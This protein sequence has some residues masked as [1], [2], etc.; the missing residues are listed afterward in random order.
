VEGKVKAGKNQV[1]YTLIEV[2]I[3][4]AIIG[5][6]GM[7]AYPAYQSHITRTNRVD[8]QAQM[9]QISSRLASY[10]L[11]NGD[12]GATHANL[13]YRAN[14]LLNPDIYGGTKY[15]RTGDQYYDL[16]ITTAPVGNWVLTVTPITSN[17]QKGDGIIVLNSEGQR[18]WV[19]A[20]TTACVPSVTSNWDGK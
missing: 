14:P 16:A 12:Y 6:L 4:V 8:M 19:K 7:V 9:M 11:A 1:G 3:V 17:R 15:P 20:S 13:D 5:V 18:C 10:R 2:M